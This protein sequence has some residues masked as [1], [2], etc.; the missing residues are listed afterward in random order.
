MRATTR[1]ENHDHVLGLGRM[2]CC[3]RCEWS[4]R[5]VGIERRYRS[6]SEEGRATFEEISTEHGLI[7]VIKFVAEK[8]GLRDHFPGSLAGVSGG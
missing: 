7:E 2:M 3:L 6:A 1:K 4:S 5:S 8:E